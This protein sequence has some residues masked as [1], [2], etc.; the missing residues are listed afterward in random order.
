MGHLFVNTQISTAALTRVAARVLLA[1]NK[2][3]VYMPGTAQQV[4]EWGGGGGWLK[5]NA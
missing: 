1:L 5:K 4:F 3:Y 2:V